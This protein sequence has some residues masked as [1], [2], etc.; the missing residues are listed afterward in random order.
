MIFL[1]KPRKKYL[2][3]KLTTCTY[4]SFFSNGSINTD[5]LSINLF[6]GISQFNQSVRALDKRR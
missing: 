1:Y 6:Y 3:V 4:F 2:K 5:F